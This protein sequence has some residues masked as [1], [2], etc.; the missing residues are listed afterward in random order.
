MKCWKGEIIHMVR[1]KGAFEIRNIKSGN[2][3][4]VGDVK[5]WNDDC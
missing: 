3:V 4:V 1:G 2:I 5:L